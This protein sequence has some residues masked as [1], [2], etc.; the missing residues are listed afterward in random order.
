M[1]FVI[2]DGFPYYYDGHNLFPCEITALSITVETDK[3]L[4]IPGKIDCIY[5]DTEIR[6][7]FGIK[8][9]ESWDGRKNKMV[10]K[11]SG[12]IKSTD[13]TYSSAE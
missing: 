10:E 7:P 11:S 6:L 12:S 13:K 8:R 3:P 9:I 4:P 1:K 2:H 5:S